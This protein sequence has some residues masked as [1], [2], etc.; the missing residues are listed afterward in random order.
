MGGR[1]PVWYAPPPSTVQTFAVFACPFLPI[2]VGMGGRSPVQRVC[3][4]AS[5]R[6]IVVLDAVSWIR[7]STRL[8]GREARL[9]PDPPGS[10]LRRFSADRVE[11]WAQGVGQSS[12][13]IGS[14]RVWRRDAGATRS[15][16]T[17]RD[18]SSSVSG[19]GGRSAA[20]AIRVLRPGPPG[21][22]RDRW[23]GLGIRRPLG[24]VRLPAMIRRW[25]DTIPCALSATMKRHGH[26][27]LRRLGGPWR[28]GNHGELDAQPEPYRLG[29]VRSGLR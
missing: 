23:M 17:M 15:G 7:R 6:L 29:R 27:G 25:A 10:A 3:A 4:P 11:E 14:S 24:G 8:S 26:V 12:R 1:S 19:R 2:P 21:L 16:E 28:R 20:A 5:A 18:G 22:D 9:I 13:S